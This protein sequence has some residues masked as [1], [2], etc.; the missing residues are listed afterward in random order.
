[1]FLFP[2]YVAVWYV[3]FPSVY[4]A[5]WYVSF[6]SVYVAGCSFLYSVYVV[7]ICVDGRHPPSKTPVGVLP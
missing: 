4:V 5:V 1:M 2:V 6:P 7:G 3:S